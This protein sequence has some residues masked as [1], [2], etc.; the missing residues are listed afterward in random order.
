MFESLANAFLLSFREGI[1]AAL[2]VMAV[3]VVVGKRTD[4][5]LK[6][7]TL[8]AVVVAVIVCSVLAIYLGT[9]ALVNNVELEV[10]LYGAAAVAVLTM[11]IWMMRHGKALKKDI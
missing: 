4:K 11:V 2:A 7:A 8:S 9:I 5:R 3:L 1:E 10:A 6:T